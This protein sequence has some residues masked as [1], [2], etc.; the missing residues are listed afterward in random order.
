MVVCFR[1]DQ[2]D[3]QQTSPSRRTR[4]AGYTRNAGQ[5]MSEFIVV[6]SILTLIGIYFANAFIGRDTKG[7]AIATGR[8]KA[9]NQVRA[10]PD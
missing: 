5:A 10:D 8:D 3:P 4:R 7:G 9:I 1:Q 6:V 2:A